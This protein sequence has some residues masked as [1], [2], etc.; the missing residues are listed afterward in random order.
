MNISPISSYSNLSYSQKSFKGG[1]NKKAYNYVKPLVAGD[2]LKFTT[3][4]AL[5]AI[6][7]TVFDKKIDSMRKDF[8]KNY[9]S[10]ID[11][12]RNHAA[13]QFE[14]SLV[15]GL[16]TDLLAEGLNLLK[17]RIKETDSAIIYD[18]EY[19]PATIEEYLACDEGGEA[20][21][22][23]EYVPKNN[24]IAENSDLG[25]DVIPPRVLFLADLLTKKGVET[26]LYSNYK[27][28]RK[29]ELTEDGKKKLIF[30][31]GKDLEDR[32]QMCDVLLNKLKTFS[33]GV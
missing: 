29:A 1:F 31:E 9:I 16:P 7:I 13:F 15:E 6:G 21:A 11:R 18:G 12:Q 3:L 10:D 32:K 8:S 4:C 28:F 30:V 26:K 14:N 22:E 20:K 25:L 17:G 33:S 24:I 23:F 2:G 27:G 19:S 5:S